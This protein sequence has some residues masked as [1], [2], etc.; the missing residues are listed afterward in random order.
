MCPPILIAATS[1]AGTALS[2]YGSIAAGN[3]QKAAA[4]AQAAADNRQASMALQQG[5]Y[6]A[7][8]KQD[9]INR[10]I[11]S[12]IASTAASGLDLSGSPSDVIA[13]TASEGALDTSAMRYGARVQADNLIYQG[14]LARQGGQVAEQAGAIGAAGGLL[15]G[16]GKFGDNGGFTLLGSAFGLNG[17][18]A[19]QKAWKLQ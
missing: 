11:G 2:A 8:R 7:D 3:A 14:K 1:L 13:S 17:Q 4:D 18:D 15:G 12:Q 5:E 16:L 10:T 9:E 19:F 6:Q